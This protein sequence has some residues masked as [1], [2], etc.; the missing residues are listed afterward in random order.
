MRIL[1]L[2]PAALIALCGVSLAHG[3]NYGTACAGAS[4]TTPSIALNGFPVTGGTF[5]IDITGPASTAGLVIAGPTQL[6]PGLD[7]SGLGLPGCELYLLQTVVDP[8]TSDVNGDVVIGPINTWNFPGATFYFQ[9]YFADSDV[10]T[11]G[12]TTDGLAITA[13]APSGNVGGELVITEIMQNPSFLGDGSGEWFELYNPGVSDIDIDGW[14]IADDGSDFH[15]IDNGGPVVVPA[16]GYVTLGNSDIAAATGGIGHVYNYGGNVFLSNGA[17][18]VVIL[19]NTGVEIDRV[20]YDGGTLF[21]DPT[22]ASMEL[23]PLLLTSTD[24]DNGYKHT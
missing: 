18:E 13:I 16:G 7:L 23:D 5:T 12:G 21:P 8:I 22:G 3:Q 1:R 17:D 19:D 20:N 2:L 24:N 9:A 15:F 6:N 4:G 11:L 10:S 14:V